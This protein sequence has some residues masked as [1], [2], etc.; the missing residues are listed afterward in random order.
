MV[1]R[2]STM[3]ETW[4]QS[5]IGKI[6]W[7]RKWQST[8]VLLPGKS[9]GQ[10]SLVGYRPWRHKELDTTEQLHFFSFTL[11]ILILYDQTYHL[12]FY[13]SCFLSK[14]LA[15]FSYDCH[16]FPKYI[17]YLNHT[18]KDSSKFFLVIVQFYFFFV[19]SFLIYLDCFGA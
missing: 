18:Y 10:R 9:H 5:W 1:K 3:R 11:N 16:S 15:Q 4:V 17:K 19:L 13:S 7:G 8:P 6:P 14:S 2:L 12:P